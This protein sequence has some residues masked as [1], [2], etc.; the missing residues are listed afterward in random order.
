GGQAR[1]AAL[2]PG[3]SEFAGL[4]SNLL[5][6][7]RAAGAELVADVLVDAQLIRREA[8]DAVVLATGAIPQRPAIEDSEEMAII[9]AAAV[10]TDRGQAGAAVV[11]A[12]E[13]CDWVG[14]GVAE[15][16]VREG[17]WVRLCVMGHSAGQ[18]LESM[19]R[20]RWLGILDGLGVEILTHLRLAGVAA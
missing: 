3:R 9:E 19:T 6:E 12:D 1:T 10:L 13:R 15:K 8:P 14:M 16:L 17:R 20:H 2:I 18:E 11:I 4:I 7:A 5:R